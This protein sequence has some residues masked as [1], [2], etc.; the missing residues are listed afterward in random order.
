MSGF[1]AALQLARGQA[2]GVVRLPTGPDDVSRS[3]VAVA[4]ASIPVALIRLMAWESDQG[5]PDNAWHI[6]AHDLLVFVVAW[7]GFLVVTYRLVER[8]GRAALWPRFVITYNWCNVVANLVVMVGAMPEALGAPETLG[9]VAQLVVTGWALWFGWF[10]IRLSL[11]TGPML[12]LYFV[13]IEQAI[14][15]GF[16]ILGAAFAPK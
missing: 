7:L 16:I 15:L 3:F 10:A 13:V 2:D 4:F 8:L 1:V 14:G 9:R 12:A 5:L 6:L 11:R